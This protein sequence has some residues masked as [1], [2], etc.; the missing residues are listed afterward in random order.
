MSW[1]ISI[2]S[3]SLVEYK[4]KSVLSKNLHKINWKIIL[5]FIFLL[6]AGFFREE[7]FFLNQYLFMHKVLG[8]TDNFSEQKSTLSIVENYHCNLINLSWDMLYNLSFSLSVGQW[9]LRFL[10]IGTVIFPSFR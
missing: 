9:Y 1:K 3:I 8:C 4:I 7:S 5:L 2:L 6:E 10:Q